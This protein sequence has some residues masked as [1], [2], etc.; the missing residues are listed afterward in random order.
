V[1]EPIDLRSDTVTRPTAAM[2]KA[3]AE[4]EVGDDV[5]GDDPTVKRLEKLG[6]E[7]LGKEAAILVPS[8]CMANLIA[9]VV[10][11]GRR[12]GALVGDASH[13]WVSE[14]GAYALVGGI[15][16]RSLPTD[17]RGRLSPSD[18]A[19]WVTDEIHLGRTG[20]LCLENTHNFCGGVALTPADVEE[21]IAP[22]REKGVKLHL[23]GARIFNAE[24]ALG[25]RADELVAPFDSA[26]FCLSKGLCSPVGSLLCGSKEFV[27][28]ARRVRKLVGG[29]MRQAG[30][31]A[32]CG[33]I[34]LEEMT[35]RLG[36]DHANARFLAEELSAVPGV[37]IDMD[38]VQTNM[39]ILD[40]AGPD[41]RGV[42]W[43]KGALAER[44]VLSLVRPP[45]G[46]L[47]AMLRLV[48]HNDVDRAACGR[49]VGIF[50]EVV[51]N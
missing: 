34:S 37:T 10:H 51:G 46:K 1:S 50:R 20:L 8:G 47:A 43:L 42:T 38:S 41:G 9:L 18:V 48:L 16:A 44:G 12:T 11:T 32:A 14:A 49:A 5:L 7:R 15:P 31:L 27:A 6:A 13:I 35:G 30:V 17:A 45:V 2:R 36:E 22:A 26:M 19:N 40:Y 23:D 24:T 3:M 28:E 21:I 33:V 4:C 29:G 39:V 25:V